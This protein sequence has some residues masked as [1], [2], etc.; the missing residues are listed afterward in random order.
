VSI[1]RKAL[2]KTPHV[3]YFDERSGGYARC[4]V[5]PNNFW[6]EYK[7]AQ[8]VADRFSPIKTVVTFDVSAEGNLDLGEEATRMETLADVKLVEPELDY[9]VVRWR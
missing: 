1:Y 6:A 7:L 5:T 3:K 9:R 8:N 4:A 2:P